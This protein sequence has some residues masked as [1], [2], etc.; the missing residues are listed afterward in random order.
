MKSIKKIFYLILLICSIMCICSCGKSSPTLTYIGHASVKIVSSN[1]SVLY[2]DP[3]YNKWDYKNQP[4]DYILVTHS[5]ED[6]KP[7]AALSLKEGV[8]HCAANY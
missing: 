7:V 4:A 3:A 1:G 2:I 6:H 8:S 5:H